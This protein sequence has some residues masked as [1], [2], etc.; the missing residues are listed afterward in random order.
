MQGHLIAAKKFQDS[1]FPF[2]SG[3][4][5][6]HFAGYPQG[7]LYPSL[8]HWLIGG[9]AK[10]TSLNFSFSF[11]VVVSVLLTPLSWIYFAKK[12]GFDAKRIKIAI[13]LQTLLY[14][15]PKN[16][17][18]GDVFGTFLIGLVNQQWAMPFFYFYLGSIAK[19]HERKNWILAGLFLGIICLSHAFV[20]F[21]SIIATFAYL[22]SSRDL[23]VLSRFSIWLK[24]IA[25]SLVVG[26]GWWLPFIMYRQWGAGI[27]IPFF[28]SSHLWGNENWGLVLLK[29][30]IFLFILVLFLN[31]KG[32][33]YHSLYLNH[34]GPL[35]F[36][37]LIFLLITFIAVV[38]YFSAFSI[39]DFFPIHLYRLQFFVLS[40]SLFL[41]S[42]FYFNEISVFLLSTL[43]FACCVFGLKYTGMTKKAEFNLGFKF[44]PDSR[45]LVYQGPKTLFDFYL[46]HKLADTIFFNNYSTT[47]GLFVESSKHSG[48]NMSL[49]FGLFDMPMTWGVKVAPFNTL[50][51]K[52]QINSLGIDA[53]VTK[54]PLPAEVRFILPIKEMAENVRAEVFHNNKKKFE[55][56]HAYT[57]KTD[58]AE[59]ISNVSYTNEKWEDVV[60]HWWT[61]PTRINSTVIQSEDLSSLHKYKVAENKKI[62]VIKKSDESFEIYAGK[63]P[64]WI[65]I[66]ESFFPLWKA[67]SNGKELPVYPCTPYMI[68][69]YGHDL[70]KFK[71]T[72]GIIDYMGHTFTL[73][74]V[75]F[76][77]I[78][79]FSTKN[80]FIIFLVFLPSCNSS[81][82]INFNEKLNSMSV[83]ASGGYHSCF[84]MDGQVFCWGYNNFSQ[85][86]D[87]SFRDSSA[88]RR[89]NH[90][91]LNPKGISLGAFHTCLWDSK[92]VECVGDNFDRQFGFK[93]KKSHLTKF[94]SIISEFEIRN[95]EILDVQSFGGNICILARGKRDE[96]FLSCAG[97]I[98][99]DDGFKFRFTFND[100]IESL[101]IG[102][103]HLCY[104]QKDEL[105]CSGSSSFGATTFHTSTTKAFAPIRGIDSKKFLAKKVSAGA[106]HTCGVF[107]DIKLKKDSIFCWGDNS[108]SQASKRN[109]ISSFYFN[110]PQRVDALD[111]VI[112][113]DVSVIRSGFAH[114]CTIINQSLFCWGSNL[115]DEISKLKR[116][117]EFPF[118]I[119]EVLIKNIKDVFLGIHSTCALTENNFLCL[120]IQGNVK[121]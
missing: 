26:A 94:K 88:P 25:F 61:S 119:R 111:S 47:N 72:R 51:V 89:A 112:T 83:I 75:L 2:L 66:K 38:D 71:F 105:F 91:I 73:L 86:G 116:K 8:F 17:M 16:S 29:A 90:N 22:I 100:P 104:I 43:T 31:F 53:I 27:G 15:A 48:L 98:W 82:G 19:I 102:E 13:L 110:L 85:L 36:I 84:I 67:F 64:K 7:F 77:L 35:I 114:T 10:F 95:K 46:P 62:N 58:F 109:K 52:D 60:F 107:Y 40:L 65:K 24:M 5:S 55:Y 69:V 44:K 23:F 1:I 93:S 50:L 103:D 74:G 11:W 21:A 108:I 34:K 18:G 99:R 78:S 113:R 3:W 20:L 63:N 57:L 42:S 37:L 9:F 87:G 33:T 68:C 80:M 70:I 76:G 14:F 30:I 59:A 117:L 120:G 115:K 32:K 56:F 106:V 121:L 54:T 92:N 79:F 101:S 49:L 96:F 118:L 97:R 28:V 12:H 81:D 39:Y 41:F 6:N 45:V 4:N